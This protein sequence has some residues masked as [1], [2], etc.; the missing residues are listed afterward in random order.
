MKR[1]WGSLVPLLLLAVAIGAQAQGLQSP[2]FPVTV[3]TKDDSV[4]PGA[5]TIVSV[6]IKIV[7]PFHIQANPASEQNL[8][9]E[10]KLTPPVGVKVGKITYPPAQH[11]SFAE[12]PAIDVYE[13]EAEILAEVSVAEDAKP[14]TLQIPAELTYQACDDKGTCKMPRTISLKVPLK[15]AGGAQAPQP[16]DTGSPHGTDGPTT[17]RTP[18]PVAI[19]APGTNAPGTDTS[20]GGPGVVPTT[21]GPTVPSNAPALQRTHRTI[22]PCPLRHRAT[23]SSHPRR[24]LRQSLPL[25]RASSTSWTCF[26]SAA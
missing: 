10:L 7:P 20:A 18:S 26:R 12:L 17:P 3:K 22:R 4:A 19:N 11:E 16:A 21:N 8:A 5:S 1:F 9:T 25:R 24:L 6:R 13:G 23:L 2:L 14:G 15:V